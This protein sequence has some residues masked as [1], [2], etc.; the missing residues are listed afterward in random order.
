MGHHKIS[1]RKFLGQASCAG[2]GYT[3]L[4]STLVNLKSINAASILNSTTVDCGGYKAMVCLLLEGGADSFNMLIPRGASEWQEYATTRSNNAI[5]Q[6]DILPINNLQSIGKDLGVHPAMSNMQSMF[7]S[8]ELGFISNIGSLINGV[9]KDDIYSGAADLPLGLFSHADQ[10]MHWQTGV[11][12]ARVA[13]GW[14]GKIADMMYACNN[15]Q[16]ISLNVSLSGSNL[17]QTGNESIEFSIDAYGGSTT[18]NGYGEEWQ[19]SEMRTQAIDNMMDAY[20]ND[21]FKKSFIDIV[22]VGKEGAE[23]FNQAIESVDLN[24]S[25]TD[26][27]LSQSFN[28][29]AKTIAARSSL[30]MSRQIFFINYGGWDHHDEVLDAQEAM[31]TEVDTA[32]GEFN[33][34]MKELGVFNDV[35][36]FSMSEFGRTLTS[37]GNGT[38]HAWGGNVFMMGGDVQGQNVFNGYPDLGLNTNIEIGGGVLIPS[39]SVDEYF[40]EIALWF[41]VP[42]SEL[43]TLFPNIG[44]FYSPGSGNPIGFLNL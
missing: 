3:T 9:T 7:N 19:F 33:A 25:F 6:T 29:V 26:N 35:L 38:D 36:T 43:V 31:L 15:N 22:K 23:Q 17:Y 5:P 32:L 18:I 24:T 34:A 16:N 13:Q 39:M 27:Y 8:G 41:G 21:M 30:G 11:P 28:M 2:L 44:N 37:N 12:H 42:S 4:M 20:Y 10:V 14:G 1:R 40:S